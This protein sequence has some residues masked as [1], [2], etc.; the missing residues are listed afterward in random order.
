MRR[1]A[2]WAVLVVIVWVGG[3]WLFVGFGL[4]A[5]LGCV[6]TALGILWALWVLLDAPRER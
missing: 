2:A 5:Y 1:I 3:G 6:A 4:L